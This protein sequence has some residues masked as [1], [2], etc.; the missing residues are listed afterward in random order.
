MSSKGQRLTDIPAVEGLPTVEGLPDAMTKPVAI[1]KSL[2]RLRLVA[3]PVGFAVGVLLLWEIY[4]RV[5]GIPPAIM[6]SPLVIGHAIS[7]YYPIL[8]QHA[9]PTTLEAA[10]GFL[11]SSLVGVLIAISIFYSRL[12][13]EALYPNLVLLQVVPKIALAPLFILWLGLGTESRLAFSVF[14]SLFP[15]V[16][17]SYTGFTRVDPNLVRLCR[18]FQAPEWLVFF[19]VRLPSALPFIFSGMKVSVTMSM[20]GVVIGEFITAQ[21]GLGYLIM[22]TSARADTPLAMAA[23][24][25]LCA[26]GLLLFGIVSGAQ[27]FFDR[28]YGGAHQ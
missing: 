12:W 3:M 21:R 20:I 9:V 22:Y 17:S 18:S 1:K 6:P 13:R 10:G 2:R 7:T 11:V 19:T 14:V 16:V 24:A 8:L 26:C 28:R 27:W 5:T 15:V 23:V 25:V 4:V